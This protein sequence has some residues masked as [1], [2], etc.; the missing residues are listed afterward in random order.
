MVAQAMLL[1]CPLFDSGDTV[2]PSD[3]EAGWGQVKQETLID[4]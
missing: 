2:V 3:V 1:C 4:D